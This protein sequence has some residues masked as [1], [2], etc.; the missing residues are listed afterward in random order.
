[1]RRVV[2]PEARCPHGVVGFLT[3]TPA[4][5]VRPWRWL[6]RTMFHILFMML[7]DAAAA[8]APGSITDTYNATQVR[9][10]LGCSSARV[11]RA[12][13]RPSV[14]VIFLGGCRT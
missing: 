11:L 12:P 3:D 14:P 9:D 13:R 8:P 1:M 7:Q 6:C 2:A 4:I 10:P 5:P